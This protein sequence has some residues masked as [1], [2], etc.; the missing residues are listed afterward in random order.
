MQDVLF[1][2]SFDRAA[3]LFHP[4]RL[5]LLRLLSSPASCPDLARR[6]GSSPQ[7]VYYHIK[8]LE[9]A[10]LVVKVEERRVRGIMEGQY[11][12]RAR[13]FWLSPDIVGR[14]GGERQV[15][16]QM[17]LAYLYQLA[18]TLQADVGHLAG[19]RDET[20]SLGLDGQIELRDAD[21]RAA[22]MEDLQAAFLG[23]ARKY[24]V[25]K[26]EPPGSRQRFKIVLAAYPAV[27]P[28]TPETTHAL[29]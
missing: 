21:D 2:E 29:N 22:F 14:V 16:D 15:Q 27:T 13:S 4:M 17:S 12:A 24:G 8:T 3:T 26:D 11:Q 28:D 10:G 20:P 18:E 23:L 6:V 25:R 19:Q 1:I 9:K 7:S 5:Q